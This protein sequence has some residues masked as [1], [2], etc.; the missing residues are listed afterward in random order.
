[1]RTETASA[2]LGALIC[3]NKHISLSSGCGGSHVHATAASHRDALTRSPQIRKLSCTRTALAPHHGGV[4]AMWAGR[5]VGP[6]WRVPRDNPWA[7][8]DVL[9]ASPAVER[10]LAG[11]CAAAGQRFE[12]ASA[13]TWTRCLAGPARGPSP[14]PGQDQKASNYLA[15]VQQGHHRD[16]DELR[17]TQS[18]SFVESRDSLRT[19][20]LDGGRCRR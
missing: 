18:S 8:A 13:R 4:S 2:V 9:L 14:L 10:W 6:T 5:V 1:M 19:L 16:T 20:G 3:T 12:E 15:V 11:P 17:S 7:R